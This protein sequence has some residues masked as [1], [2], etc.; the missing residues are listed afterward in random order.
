MSRVN[1]AIPKKLDPII[2][3]LM[4]KDKTARYASAEELQKDLD[5]LDTRGK[6]VSDATGGSGGG[7]VCCCWPGWRGGS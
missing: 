1:P 6:G 2:Q 5:G 4:A 3:K 7:G